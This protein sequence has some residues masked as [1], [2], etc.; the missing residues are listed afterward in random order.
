MF[1]SVIFSVLCLYKEIHGET[2]EHE[3][4]QFCL[5]FLYADNLNLTFQGGGLTELLNDEVQSQ[6]L[7]FSTKER[8]AL[9]FTS[10]FEDFSVDLF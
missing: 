8:G 3:H 9:F 6:N 5:R 4:A 7:D 2:A 10:E 1:S